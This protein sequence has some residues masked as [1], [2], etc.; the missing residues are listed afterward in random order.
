M[1]IERIKRVGKTMIQIEKKRVR[2]KSNVEAE[3][4]NE[5]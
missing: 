2:Q 4:E 3:L 5:N 1:A